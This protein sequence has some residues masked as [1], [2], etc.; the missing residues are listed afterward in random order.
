M[1]SWIY[2]QNKVRVAGRSTP[3]WR[4]TINHSTILAGVGIVWLSLMRMGSSSMMG[5]SGN[6]RSWS[7]GGSV[8]I[9]TT[10]TSVS[11]A[12]TAGTADPLVLGCWLSWPNSTSDGMVNHPIPWARYSCHLPLA[13][14]AERL[15][16]TL[17]GFRWTYVI[18]AHAR[19]QQ[20]GRCQP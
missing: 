17:C 13:E 3:V 9:A 20:L 14:V 7:S 16:P 4:V 12:A 18:Q 10:S 6:G 1:Y 5:D 15:A 2:T 8:A 11:I 19:V